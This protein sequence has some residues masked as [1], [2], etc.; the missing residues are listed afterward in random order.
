MDNDPFQ[1]TRFRTPHGD[2]LIDF[3][4]GDLYRNW[5]IARGLIDAPYTSPNPGFE[6][7]PYPFDTPTDEVWFA[8]HTTSEPLPPKQEAPPKPLSIPRRRGVDI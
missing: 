5:C 6:P 2:T 3:P 4:I 1:S 7:I 8:E